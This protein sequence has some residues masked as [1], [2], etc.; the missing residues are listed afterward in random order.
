M[1]DKTLLCC[2]ILQV[3]LYD[4]QLSTNRLQ[5]D[6]A[7]IRDCTSCLSQS[8]LHTVPGRAEHNTVRRRAVQ[9]RSLQFRRKY[10]KEWSI[11]KHY[12]TST[13]AHLS[14]Q[15]LIPAKSLKSTDTSVSVSIFQPS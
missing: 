7:L 8:R 5:S 3:S 15:S 4:P 6:L 12:R 1:L 14:D 10:N 11:P 13:S 2:V 9:A